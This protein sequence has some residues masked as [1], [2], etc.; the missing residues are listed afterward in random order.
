MTGVKEATAILEA[1]F[2][3]FALV[4][5]MATTL[6]SVL[7]GVMVML[8]LIYER[9]ILGFVVGKLCCFLRRRQLNHCWV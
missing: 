2:S 9:S 5:R 4:F 6:R 3:R 7:T 1:N 8:W